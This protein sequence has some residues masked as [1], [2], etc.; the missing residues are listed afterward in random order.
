M[1]R[2]DVDAPGGILHTQ[3]PPR[4]SGV[5]L[6]WHGGSTVTTVWP[7]LP[8]A[9]VETQGASAEVAGTTCMT[10]YTDLSLL[11]G[12]EPVAPPH[13]SRATLWLPPAE[14][15]AA[16]AEERYP[17]LCIQAAGTAGRREYVEVV[18]RMP[19]SDPLYH[20]ITLVV[21][22]VRTAMRHDDA[23]YAEALT[24][25]LALHLLRRYRATQGAEWLRSGGLTPARLQR[26]LAYIQTHLEEDLSLV[27][28]ATVAQISPKYFAC[29]FKQ[30]TGR[31]PHQYVLWCRMER[32][33]QLLAETDQALCEAAYQ[34]GCTD[35]SHFTGLFRRYVGTTPSAYRVAR[36]CVR[37]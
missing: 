1:R 36:G 18:T 12:P 16:G 3:F 24:H 23:L 28:L 19:M 17:A 2:G 22:A 15:G 29:L 34:V 27:Q 33:Q 21:Q 32:A 26:T 7:A 37:Q 10:F 5:R 20:H 11:T 14:P 8:D 4:T 6:H 35:Q 13:V 31:T 9:D 25:A 30:A